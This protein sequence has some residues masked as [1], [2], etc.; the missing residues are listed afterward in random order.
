MSIFS[1]SVA[2]T[3][4]LVIL[5]LWIASV[6]VAE[7]VFYLLGDR[8]SADL[9]GLY[10]PFGNQSYKLGELVNTG[11]NWASGRFTIYTD[12]LGLRCDKARQSGL[13]ANE[14]IDYLF[15]GDSQGFGN[16]VNFEDTIPGSFAA[17]AGPGLNV[18]NASVGGHGTLNQLELLEWLQ[19]KKGV[20]VKNYILLLTPL[21][22][23]NPESYNRAEVGADGRL[24]DGKKSARQ[25]AM[26]WLKSHSLVYSRFRDAVRSL[27][28]GGVP[29]RDDP[30]ILR[31]FRS[32][33]PEDELVAKLARFLKR[34]QEYVQSQGA[35][36]YLAYVPLTVEVEFQGVQQAA[37]Q[38]GVAVDSSRPLR[39][40][41]SAAHS[42][43]MTLLDLRPVLGA[44]QAKGQMLNLLGDFHYAAPVSKACGSELWDEISRSETEVRNP[45]RIS[46]Q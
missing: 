24:Y 6:P 21:M 43:G 40:A 16:G 12:V 3:N 31:I 38:K 22:A 8:P 14:T 20:S 15:V 44:M 27:G 25:M 42:A 34:F 2:K 9:A 1:W 10:V 46:K 13:E 37:S 17:S 18:A 7:R 28:I 4:I 45:G 33:E 41:K 35:N 36:V 30:I 26:I 5:L 29:T 32:G 23:L 19:E 39:I 11:A